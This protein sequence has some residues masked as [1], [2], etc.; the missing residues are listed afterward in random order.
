MIKDPIVEEVH[1]ARRE[2]MAECD[3]D[4]QKLV[5]RLRRRQQASGRRIVRPAKRP[6]KTMAGQ[7]RD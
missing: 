7:A 5:K 3:N 4:L 2:I 6:P 1:Q